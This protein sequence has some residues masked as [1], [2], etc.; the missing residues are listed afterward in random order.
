MLHFIYL[1]G[2]ERPDDSQHLIFYSGVA[3]IR[4]RFAEYMEEDYYF[5]G[6]NHLRRE[7]PARFL[8]ERYGVEWF[9]DYIIT[10]PSRDGKDRVM[11][12]PTCLDTSVQ[13]AVDLVYLST[14]T[15][16][17]IVF[18]GFVP[19]FQDLA[20]ISKNCDDLT[21][22]VSTDRTLYLD[23]HSEA[24]MR[25]AN[26]AGLFDFCFRGKHYNCSFLDFQKITGR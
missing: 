9:D 11:A 10:I 23:K 4:K 20:W 8:R 14:C 12:S 1:D 16:C 7:L 6:E 21:I 26:E 22:Y 15:T 18:A 13:F 5:I 2:D 17:G 25:L 24:E 19:R 3:N